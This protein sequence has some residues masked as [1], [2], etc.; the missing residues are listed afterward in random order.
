MTKYS[1]RWLS[2]LYKLSQATKSLSVL[3]REAEILAQCN[4]RLL[5]DNI[6]WA[7]SYS[8]LAAN[9]SELLSSYNRLLERSKLKD[10]QGTL[11]EE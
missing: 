10:S 6:A 3:K 9:H 8:N 4:S 7:K 5:K 2:L 1:T 11:V